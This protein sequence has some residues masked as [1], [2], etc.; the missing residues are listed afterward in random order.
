MRPVRA[1]VNHP[2]SM[3]RRFGSMG[4]I[5][6]MAMDT[7]EQYSAAGS[8]PVAHDDLVGRLNDLAKLRE[9][10]VLSQAEFEIAKSRLLGG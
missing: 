7:A 4:W 2:E 3:T 6:S 10:G 1:A 9:K 8:G 5:A